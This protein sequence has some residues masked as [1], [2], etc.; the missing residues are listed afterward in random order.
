MR[1]FKEGDRKIIIVGRIEIETPAAIL[2]NIPA[3]DI[4]G[5]AVDPVWFPLSQVYEIH[6]T[7]SLIKGTLDC[8]IVTAWIARQKGIIE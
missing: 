7:G 6:R 8:I 3:T 4:D 1:K 2:L 5:N